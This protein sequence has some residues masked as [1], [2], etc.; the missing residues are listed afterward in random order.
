MFFCCATNRRARCNTAL[1]LR[2]VDDIC[3]LESVKLRSYAIHALSISRS[4]EFVIM[5]VSTPWAAQLFRT[6]ALQ[7]AV[8]VLYN[9][10]PRWLLILS[11]WLVMPNNVDKSN[12]VLSI[13]NSNN[14][15]KS[16]CIDASD[17]GV[18]LFTSIIIFLILSKSFLNW[19]LSDDVC[20]SNSASVWVNKVSTSSAVK[21]I[22]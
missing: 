11:F 19:L 7:R 20:I 2:T 10:S 17:D 1:A 21:P 15:D 4:Y 5:L 22:Y 16:N 18:P 8:A 13:V 3:S 14:P 12:P 6:A 9:C